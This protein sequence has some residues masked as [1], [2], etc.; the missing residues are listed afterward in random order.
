MC[1]NTA[2]LTRDCPVCTKFAL[3]EKFVL[4][5][6]DGTIISTRGT[7]DRCGGSRRVIVKGDDL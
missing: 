5:L 3:V 7:C 4:M 2:M 1:L 6:P